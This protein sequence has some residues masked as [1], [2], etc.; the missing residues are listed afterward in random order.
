[1]STARFGRKWADVDEED[2]EYTGTSPKNNFFEMK[3]KDGIKT[4]YSYTERDKKTYKITK[5]VRQTTVT[6]WTNKA[7]ESRKTMPKFGKALVDTAEENHI[8]HSTE[9][10]PI[11]CTRKMNIVTMDAED[12][13]HEE[14]IAMMENLTKEKK[15]WTDVNR[16]KQEERDGDKAPPPA[17]E[18]DPKMGSL[19]EALRKKDDGAPAADGAKRYVPPSMRGAG[20]AA[21]P[22]GRPDQQQQQENSLRVFNLSEDVRE[23][24]LS[25]L[26]SPCG[27]LQRV[28]LAKHM[29][30]GLSKG[31]AFVTFYNREDAQRAIAKLNGHGYDNLIMK[32]EWAKPRA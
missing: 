9:E 4:V 27:R 13:F 16:E 31:F 17:E 6:R 12:K 24:D 28:F 3:D 32:V 20:A 25:E 1:M 8:T 19:A 22:G 2:D 10:V 23:G 30:T 15:V 7:I 11:E 5:R 18:V 26:F 21:G 29:D 14:S